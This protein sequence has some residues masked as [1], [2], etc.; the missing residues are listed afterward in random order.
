M[1]LG[2]AILAIGRRSRTAL[3]LAAFLVATGTA[4]LFTNLWPAEAR[5]AYANVLGYVMGVT[6]GAAGILVAFWTPGAR[7][8]AAWPAFAGIAAGLVG[9]VGYFAEGS[10]IAASERGLAQVGLPASFALAALVSGSGFVVGPFAALV[11]ASLRAAIA[12]PRDR[13][14]F[15]RGFALV[16]LYAPYAIFYMPRQFYADW[17]YHAFFASLLLVATLSALWLVVAARSGRRAGVWAAAGLAALGCASYAYFG[18]LGHLASGNDPIG[19][20]GVARLCGWTFL[21]Y[22]ILRADLLG[23]PL[24]RIAVNRG[25]VAA[26]SLAVLFIV[27]Q[28]AQNFLAA[29]YG[30]VM[31]GVVAGAFL[32]AAAPLQRAI[33]RTTAVAGPPRRVPV[34]DASAE[35]LY[36]ENLR[37][38]LQD[39]RVSAEEEQHLAEL[40]ERL[41]IPARRAVALRHEVEREKGAR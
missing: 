8:R 28:L 41:G 23:V 34:V 40:G 7:S 39:R 31:G 29:E 14:E 13:A 17:S 4:N 2:L 1:L 24:P 20:Y 38:V 33:E 37:L 32:F 16:G 25:A 26:G 10:P 18:E 5:P 15:V 9:L 3:A 6:M 30:L 19:L 27:A 11:A 22:A 35:V 12:P 36:R 21:V